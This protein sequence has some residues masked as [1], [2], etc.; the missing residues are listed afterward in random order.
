[1]FG[2]RLGLAVR[3]AELLGTEAIE[4]GL[5]GPRELP[6]L[7]DRHLLNCAAL[8]EL[9]EP[10]A[11]VIDV[12]SGAGLPG[13]PLALARPDLE[14]TLVEPLLRRSSWLTDVVARLG[15]SHVTVYRA[16]AEELHGRLDAQCVTA[17]ALAP[18][19]R[20][21]AWCLP[22]VRPG[23]ML[24]AMKGQSVMA[25]LAEAEPAIRRL[26]G[27]DCQVRQVGPAT[28][29]DRT[30]VVQVKVGSS[31][32]GIATATPSDAGSRTVRRSAG[33]TK[34]RGGGR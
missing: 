5:I 8:A 16:R 19:E 22:L 15:L 12:G 20:L 9:V 28:L 7:W 30:S 21:A 1:M 24:L 14:V 17:R 6:R 33:A 31:A 11:D 23:G 26:G 10:S 34:K 25:E 13:I 18:M 3:Y 2:S 32:P 29:L 4:R 27:V